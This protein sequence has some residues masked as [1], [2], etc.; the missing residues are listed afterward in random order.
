LSE[1]GLGLG[2][3]MRWLY[4]HLRFLWGGS[5]FPRRSGSI[6]EGQP[7]PSDKLNLQPGEL[8]RVKTHGQVLQTLSTASK[9]RGL[10]WDAEMVPYCGQTHRV[11]KRVTQI[12]DEKSGRMQDMRN[13]CIVLESVTCQSRYSGCR[14]FCPRSIYSYWREVWLERVSSGNAQA[15]RDGSDRRHRD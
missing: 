10:W 3:P 9:N 15:D 11:L 2:K 1:A 14:M 7:T 5:M 6:P 12:I 13:P 4:D 8:V